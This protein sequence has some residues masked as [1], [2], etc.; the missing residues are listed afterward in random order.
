MKFVNE[1]LGARPVVAVIYSHS[2]GDH[3]VECA[4][5]IDEA[6]VRNGKVQVIAP[7]AENAYAGNA[8]TRRMFY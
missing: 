2:H 8:M 7:V 3:S 6:D 4:A 5:C 1:K